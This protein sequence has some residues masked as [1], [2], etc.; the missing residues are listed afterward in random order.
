M[1]ELVR[2]WLAYRENVKQ[3]RAFLRLPHDPNDPECALFPDHGDRL[4][5]GD[6]NARCPTCNPTPVHYLSPRLGGSS[7]HAFP[8][9]TAPA[10]WDRDQTKVTCSICKAILEHEGDVVTR[11][12]GES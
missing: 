11:L 6:W 3:D 2:R 10:E 5:L 4:I 8:D 1:L 12:R 7:L 9:V